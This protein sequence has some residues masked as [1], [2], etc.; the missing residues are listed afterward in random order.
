VLALR[1][2]AREARESDADAFGTRRRRENSRLLLPALRRDVD[3]ESKGETVT[4]P[5]KREFVYIAFVVL[6]MIF[7]QT[8]DYK[9]AIVTE[10][11]TKEQIEKIAQKY[12][13]IIA[14]CANGGGFALDDILVHCDA[15][16]VKVRR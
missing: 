8:Q 4:R 10:Q 7:V 16:E 9:A 2:S 11:V 5:R 1:A 12:A 13:G 15:H 14:H 6:L 3:A